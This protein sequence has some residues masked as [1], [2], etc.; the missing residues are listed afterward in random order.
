MLIRIETLNKYSVSE[1][2][3][4]STMPFLVSEPRRKLQE[5]PCF[6][7]PVQKHSTDLSVSQSF[8]GFTLLVTFR[9]K[10]A[11]KSHK[12][13]RYIAE[14][15]LQIGFSKH[16]PDS[17]M[18]LLS[19]NIWKKNTSLVQKWSGI[20]INSVITQCPAKCDASKQDDSMGMF[21]S[22]VCSRVLNAFK[23]C[24]CYTELTD[25][26]NT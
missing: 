13:S 24:K 11:K 1:P 18:C 14:D 2:G 9:W 25:R 19:L 16:T 8:S 7:F 22:L 12:I 3:I 10:K 21:Y 26:V 17:H 6:D 4:E 5:I 20:L 23:A 15:Q